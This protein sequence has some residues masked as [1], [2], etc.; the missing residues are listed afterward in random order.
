MAQAAK[1][2]GNLLVPS[3]K[4][5]DRALAVSANHAQR[6]AEAFGLKVPVTVEK[7]GKAPT[8][9]VRRKAQV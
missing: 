7:P 9:V 6:M 8:P 2:P 1:T 3:P 4:D 5:L